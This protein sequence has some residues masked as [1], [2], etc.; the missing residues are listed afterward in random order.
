MGKLSLNRW[1]ALAC[2]CGAVA[3]AS[4]SQ[5]KLVGVN[6]AVQ[7]EGIAAGLTATLMVAGVC[8]AAN[9]LLE[10]PWDC[11]VSK[12]LVLAQMLGVMEVSIIGA[13]FLVYVV[14]NWDELVAAN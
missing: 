9:V 13:Y 4:I 1:L 2:I 6:V 8:V 10:K 7:L 5:L 11:P 12:A 14:P 3:L